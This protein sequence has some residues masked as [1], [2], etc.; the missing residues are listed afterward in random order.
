MNILVFI[1]AGVVTVMVLIVVGGSFREWNIGKDNLRN[2]NESGLK[3]MVK[4]IVC[5]LIIVIIYAIIF[6]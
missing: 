5:G 1:F 6:S 4:A 2:R 3:S